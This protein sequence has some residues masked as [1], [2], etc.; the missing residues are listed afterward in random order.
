MVLLVLVVGCRGKDRLRER[1]LYDRIAQRDGKNGAQVVP[2]KMAAAG[3]VTI[4]DHCAHET[5]AN[6]SK[7][8]IVEEAGLHEDVF[9]LRDRESLAPNAYTLSEALR[10]EAMLR[11]EAGA[12][13]HSKA[14]DECIGAFAQHLATLTDALIQADKIQKEMDV[15]AYNDASKQAREQEEQMEKTQRALEQIRHR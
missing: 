4:T 14:Q 15:S 5:Y 13:G 12:A 6:A 1:R 7:G 11:A 10:L 3:T 2:G 8:L 9:S